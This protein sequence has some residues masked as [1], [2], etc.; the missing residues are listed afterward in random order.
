MEDES[1]RLRGDKRIPSSVLFRRLLKYTK[2]HWLSI[3]F[4]LFFLLLYAGINIALPLVME[5]LINTLNPSHDYFSL[6]TV[7]WCAVAYGGLAIFDQLFRLFE[8]FLLQSTGQ[9]IIYAMRMD[10]FRHIE[11]MSQNQF[12]EMPVGALVTRVAN[13]T[14]AIS[15]MF[16]DALV[17]LLTNALTIVGAFSVM[18][19]KS[20]RLSLALLG[21]AIVIALISYFFWKTMSARF[22]EERGKVSDLNIFV[23]ENLSGM[24]ITQIFHQEEKKKKEF[25][26]KNEALRKAAY[27]VNVSFTF[28]RPV[29]SFLQYAA[30]ATTFGIGI[31][32]HFNSG[33]IVA[34]YMLISLFFRP[35]QN[36]SDQLNQI[37]SAL[38]SAERLFNLLDVPPEVV[39]SPEAVKV[40]HF[41]GEIEFQHVYF[42]YEP[43]EWILKDVSFHIK[44]GETVA[45]VGATGAGKTTILSLIVRNYS[46]QRGKILIDGRN[47]NDIE[48]ASLRKGI[49]QMLQ[50]VFLFK[51]SISSNLTLRDNE[52]TMEDIHRASEYVGADHF[53]GRL[54]NG[55]EEEI[56]A[57]GENL[58]AG[59]RQLL[60]FARTVLHKPQ[61][62]ILD[63]ATANID[64]ETEAI[65]QGS[66]EKMKSIG[67]MLVVAH[68]LSTIQHADNIIVLQSGQI[69]EQGNHQSLLKQRGQYYRLYELQFK[70]KEA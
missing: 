2:G 17:Q 58:S 33:E 40:D 59:Q 36:L 55:Y 32:L 14:A 50:D 4:A 70:E 42:A 6:S 62:L 54:K 65:I 52:F 15:R 45:F 34:F 24:R 48:I 61:I 41:E 8:A 69:I 13:Y 38:T 63:E 20:W 49:G 30:I 53:I 26:E 43:G 25:Q 7:I 64:T 3:S 11:G 28:Y 68:R 18:V 39:N 56:T 51:G 57:G 22:R 27:G 37:T 16:T 47:I 10:V 35:I 46:P 12:N 66:L 31:S 23:S 1:M 9:K 5:F 19:T 44:K 67:T 21:F 60:S 29:I